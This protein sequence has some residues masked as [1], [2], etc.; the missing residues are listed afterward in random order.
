MLSTDASLKSSPVMAQPMFSR[1]WGFDEMT[2]FLQELPPQ[3]RVSQAT[4]D[5]RGKKKKGKVTALHFA[6]GFCSGIWSW[7]L[8][9]A[10]RAGMPLGNMIFT[11]ACF[12]ENQVNRGAP[13][14]F[15][16]KKCCLHCTRFR[17]AGGFGAQ[18]G[19]PA[20]FDFRTYG[21]SASSASLQTHTHWHVCTY[22]CRHVSAPMCHKTVLYI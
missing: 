15:L 18:Q 11:S 5:L 1:V 8:Q 21:W 22:A 16:R 13:K 9:S 4:E 7:F 2:G 20:L 17:P 10:A 6:G 12:S 3:R 19:P 14:A